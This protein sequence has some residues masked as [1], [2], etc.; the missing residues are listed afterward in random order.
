MKKAIGGETE[1]KAGTSESAITPEKVCNE[2]RAYMAIV[3]D[4][5]DAVVARD[6]PTYKLPDQ[7][8]QSLHGNRNLARGMERFA[9]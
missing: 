7:P 2:G 1:R 4:Q 9:S 5:G 8:Q 6:K 3:I